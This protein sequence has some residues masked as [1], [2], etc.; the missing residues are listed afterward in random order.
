MI[1][2]AALVHRLIDAQFPEWVGLPVI[3]VEPNGRDNRTFRLGDR[4]SV[5][6][7]S[8][9]AYVAQV[10]KEHRWL[11]LL[12]PGLPLPIPAPIAKGAPGVGYPWPWSVYRWLDGRVAAADR[13][14][15]PIEFARSLVDFLVSLQRIDATGGRHQGNTISIGA[16]RSQYTIRR[17]V[18]RFLRFGAASISR[19]QKRYGPP[20]LARSGCARRFGYMAISLRTICSSRK[21]SSAPLSILDV[22]QQ[23]ILRATL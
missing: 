10:E 17:P 19:R 16:G 4:M 1:I 20:H 18:L 14:T 22:W 8:A 15:D 9:E 2:D 13:I 5:R 23:A 21:G 12:Q 3:P 6:L 7:P 11:P